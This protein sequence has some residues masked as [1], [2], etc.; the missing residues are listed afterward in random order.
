GLAN[1]HHQGWIM[2]IGLPGPDN[3]KGGKHLILPPGYKG[4]APGGYYV[5]QSLSNKVLLA[6]RALPVGGDVDAAMDALR[7]IRIYPLAS[8]A[9]PQLAAVIDSTQMKMDNTSLRWENNIQFW[10]VLH[11]ILN[12]E[13]IVE[14]YLPMYGLLAALGVERGRPFAPDARMKA[15]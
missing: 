12:E 2:D 15:V 10:D 7:K 11:R 1:D 6:V 9:N 13:P 5:G 8:V 3:G 4:E 14:K